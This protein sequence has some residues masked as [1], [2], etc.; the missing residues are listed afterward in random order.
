MSQPV[1]RS[2]QNF[3]LMEFEPPLP[4]VVSVDAFSAVSVTDKDTEIWAYR[5]RFDAMRADAGSPRA[6]HD[7]LKRAERELER[8]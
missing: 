4:T 6:T 2:G 3:I 5:R 1:Y 7:F 8:S